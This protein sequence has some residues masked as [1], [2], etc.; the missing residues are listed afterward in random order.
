MPY[1]YNSSEHEILREEVRSLQ[2]VRSRQTGRVEQLE[3][4]IKQLKVSSRL[5]Q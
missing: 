2:E 3:E 1:E 5:P 4:E